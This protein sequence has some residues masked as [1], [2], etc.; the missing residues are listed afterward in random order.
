MHGKASIL[1]TLIVAAAPAR[2][3]DVL[4]PPSASPTS[5]APA[6][7][8]AWPGFEIRR[9]QELATLAWGAQPMPSPAGITAIPCADP[10]V[11][12]GAADPMPARTRYLPL[13]RAAECRHHLPKGL[14]ASLI[15]AESAY[16]VRARSRVGAVGLT[17]LM[18]RT[19]V[20]VGV[21]DR[22][23][24]AR[25]IEGGARYLGRMIERFGEVR[26]ALAAYNA[27]PGAVMRAGGVPDNGE[28]PGYVARVIGLWQAVAV[29]GVLPV[30]ET[31]R[32]LPAAQ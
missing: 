11:A 8:P 1:A 32:G 15:G 20:E 19:A 14:L 9:T 25:S 21:N 10:P 16:K 5:A 22:L 24:P 3:A 17:Q 23:D 2:A 26:L 28:T 27:G 31:H 4:A 6:T 12:M 18:P 7:L 29:D 30:L 13:I